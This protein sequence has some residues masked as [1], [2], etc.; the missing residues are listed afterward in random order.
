ME[1]NHKH[2][3]KDLFS[4]DLGNKP[5]SSRRLLD[6]IQGEAGGGNRLDPGIFF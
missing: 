6:L 4:P 1:T 5:V 3:E 2:E